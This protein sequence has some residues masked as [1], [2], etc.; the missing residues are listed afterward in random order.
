MSS[1]AGRRASRDA[2]SREQWA[3]Q[4]AAAEPPPPTGPGH[5]A[6]GRA[7]RA[8][9]P[10]SVER[11]VAAALGAVEAAGFEELTMRSVAAALDTGPASLYAHVRSKAELG[12]LL[13]G[14]L[15]TRVV[16]A[17]PDPGRWR[18]QFL[19]VCTQLREQFLRYPGIS[20]AALAVVPADLATLRVGENLLAILLAGGASARAA[21]WASDGAF[22]YVTAYCLE[23][24]TARRQRADVDGRVLDRAEITERLQ[25][26]PAQQFP[27][28][29]AH[30]H[31]LTAGAG[32]ERFDFVVDLMI[33]GLT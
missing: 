19:D 10:I 20:Q 12:D 25:M 31:E 29:V 23:A 1:V 21:A 16:L 26:L 4:I 33:R 32:H 13:I 7:R 5:G 17:V 28:T 3:T 14:E 30:A 18:E 15:C 8:G 22:L 6:S 27:H 9:T 24:A 2:I 11:I